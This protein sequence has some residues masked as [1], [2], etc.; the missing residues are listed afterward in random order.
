[1]KR[2]EWGFIVWNVLACIEQ[3][4]ERHKKPVDLH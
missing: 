1:M 4:T 3:K 2:R